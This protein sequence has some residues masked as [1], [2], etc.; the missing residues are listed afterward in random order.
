MQPEELNALL[1][2]GRAAWLGKLETGLL[3][4]Q[5]VPRHRGLDFCKA[6]TFQPRSE[7]EGTIGH[8][9]A[10]IHG[11]HHG[12]GIQTYVLIQP[13]KAVDIGD[14]GVAP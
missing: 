6:F 1:V 9:N 10:P 3:R 12:P 8:A 5:V 11:I 13:L 2:I 7:I 14:P 4:E